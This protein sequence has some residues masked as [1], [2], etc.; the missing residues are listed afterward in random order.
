LLVQAAWRLSRS[1]DPRTESFRTWAQAVARRRGKRVA[2]VALARRL[3]RTLFAMWRDEADY[4]PRRIRTRSAQPV[5]D[6]TAKTGTG[7]PM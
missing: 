4:Q 3:T 7:A 1:T 5:A 2:M 6:A